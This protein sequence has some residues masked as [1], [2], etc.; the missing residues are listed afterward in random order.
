MGRVVT[1]FDE[2]KKINISKR[3]SFSF[4]KEF[5]FVHKEL[6]KDI[7]SYNPNKINKTQLAD[8]WRIVMARYSTKKTGGVLKHSIEDIIN[9]AGIIYREIIKRVKAGK[10]KHK[11]KPDKMTALSRELYN[12]VSKNKTGINKLS[13]FRLDDPKLLEQ[14]KDKTIIKDFISIIGSVAEK[15]PGHKPNDMDLLIRMSNPTDFIKRAVETRISKE[16]DFSDNLHFVWGDPEGPH[17]SFIPLYLF[18][19]IPE[20]YYYELAA[21][22]DCPLFNCHRHFS[23]ASSALVRFRSVPGE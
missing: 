14:F 10:M 3:G 15:R 6:I 13:K 2:P 22:L 4:I 17:D 20:I 18:L 5:E 21:F 19:L 7:S 23:P 8:D 11:F 9:I 12:I 16:L 1:M